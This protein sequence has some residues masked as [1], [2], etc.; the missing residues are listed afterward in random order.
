MIG[1]TVDEQKTFFLGMGAGKSGSTWIY[2]YLVSNPDIEPGPLKEMRVLSHPEYGN[3]IRSALSL[4]Y[5][6]FEGR[7]W[8]KENAKRITYR[9]NWGKYFSAYDKILSAGAKATGENSPGNMG[10]SREAL[11]KVRQNF[12]AIGVR[13]VPIFIMRDPIERLRSSISY[14][15]KRSRESRYKLYKKYDQSR[16]LESVVADESHY[17]DYSLEYVD[18]VEKIS[19]V[20][21]SQDIFFGFYEEIFSEKEMRRLCSILGVRYVRA[22]FDKKEN[23]SDKKIQ[24]S[25]EA[26]EILLRRYL[27]VY[28]ELSRIFGRQRIGAVWP[29]SK[30][31]LELVGNVQ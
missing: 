4:P 10:I 15:S 2:N 11:Q 14:A 26:R 27:N 5:K 31:A 12:N 28:S 9:A 19:S 21:P 17:H 16:L 25:S 3:I 1:K 20:F 29:S 7:W 24:V 13:V 8:I 6:K 22:E 23:E 18:T 30:E